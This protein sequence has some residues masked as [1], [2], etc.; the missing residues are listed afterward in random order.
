M[1]PTRAQAE[2]VRSDWTLLLL[3]AARYL[4]G[5]RM[6]VWVEEY[7]FRPELR[8]ESMLTD[9]TVSRTTVSLNAQLLNSTKHL[10]KHVINGLLNAL[11]K[12]SFTI[13]WSAGKASRQRR[14]E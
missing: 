4:G 7:E 12:S 10:H 6:A 1:R 9:E 8:E 5:P 13:T 11:E 14:A 2:T 3:R